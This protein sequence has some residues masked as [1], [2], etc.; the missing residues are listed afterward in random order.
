MNIP[1]E[2]EFLEAVRNASK[3]QLEAIITRWIRLQEISVFA[4]S[5]AVEII[6]NT[7]EERK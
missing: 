5:D 2:E 3:A 7:V 1:T 6:A 4:M